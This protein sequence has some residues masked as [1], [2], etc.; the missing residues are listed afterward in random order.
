MQDRFVYFQ[1]CRLVLQ[2]C[3]FCIYKQVIY[4]LQRCNSF[5]QASSLY[6]QACNCVL[7]AFNCTLLA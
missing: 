2:V 7:Q 1:A 5:L 4:F 6:L 3:N